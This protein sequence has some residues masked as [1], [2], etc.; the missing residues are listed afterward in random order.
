MTEFKRDFKRY[1][2]LKSTDLDAAAELNLLTLDDLGALD[3]IIEAVRNARQWRNKHPLYCAVIENDWPEYELV[4]AMLAKRSKMDFVR[5]E[6]QKLLEENLVYSDH[7]L[8]QI[9]G[10]LEQAEPL[11]GR[12]DSNG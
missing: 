12:G 5:T 7:V 9:M 2:V 1:I 8:R 10:I 6:I 11:P 3:R 4:W